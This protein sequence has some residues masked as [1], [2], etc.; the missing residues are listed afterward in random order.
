MIMQVLP[1]SYVIKYKLSLFNCYL[2]LAMFLLSFISTAA[3]F[4]SANHK[5]QSNTW[6]Y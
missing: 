5:P 3:L 2:Y 6:H 4:Y 1:A